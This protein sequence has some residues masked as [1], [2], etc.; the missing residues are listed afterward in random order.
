MGDARQ[1]G[2]PAESAALYTSLILGRI[3]VSALGSYLYPL[4]QQQ[5]FSTSPITEVHHIN[6]FTSCNRFSQRKSSTSFYSSH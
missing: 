2:G 3:R 5:K 6:L 1:Q 4:Q